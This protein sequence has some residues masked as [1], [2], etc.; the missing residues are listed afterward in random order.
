[1]K[2]GCG[3]QLARK[4]WALKNYNGSAHFMCGHNRFL[5]EEARKNE[6]SL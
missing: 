3:K 4:K 5:V 6:T 1:M 2:K